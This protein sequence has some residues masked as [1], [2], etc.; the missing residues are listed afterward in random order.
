M[1]PSWLKQIGHRRVEAFEKYNFKVLAESMGCKVL[2]FG[3]QIEMDKW[4]GMSERIMSAHE[5]LP[6]NK[7][8]TIPGVGHDVAD[9][10][11]IAAIA[12]AI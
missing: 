8:I 2:L 12:T 11:Y 5:L 6:N 1:K 9:S 3:G 10:H 4:P 7:L